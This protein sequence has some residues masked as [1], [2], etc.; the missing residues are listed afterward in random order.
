M[1]LI[2]FPL[3]FIFFLPS[4]FPFPFKSASHTHPHHFHLMMQEPNRMDTHE[5]LAMSEL[6][7]AIRPDYGLWRAIE[8]F[9]TFFERKNGR[10]EVPST[11]LSL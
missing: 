9:K 2:S 7:I 10:D 1:H 6:P 11:L 8:T 3:F 4:S 5:S